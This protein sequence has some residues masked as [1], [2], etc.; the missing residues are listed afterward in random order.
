MTWCCPLQL[1]NSYR[2]SSPSFDLHSPSR[3]WGLSIISSA[4]TSR[5]PATG[6]SFHR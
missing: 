4:S 6:S 5:V 3:T 2:T 1:R